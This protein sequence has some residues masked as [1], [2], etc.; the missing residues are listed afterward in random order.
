MGEEEIKNSIL[1]MFSFIQGRF[2]GEVYVTVDEVKARDINFQIIAI[3]MVDII[4]INQSSQYQTAKTRRNHFKKRIL[5]GCWVT[6]RIA[7]AAKNEAQEIVMNK[8]IRKLARTAQ[9][10]IKPQ[11]LSREDTA[12]TTTVQFGFSDYT[13]CTSSSDSWMPLQAPLLLV[14][15]KIDV[16]AAG[17]GADFLSS[18]FLHLTSPK[19]E[20][21]WIL[22]IGQALA[23]CPWVMHQP[24]VRYV[25]SE[26]QEYFGHSTMLLRVS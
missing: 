7:R 1:Q 18:L 4:Y 11:I 2:Q 16:A 26:T 8:G 19:V 23:M 6:H 15:W 17:I 12:T 22:L 13:A 3:H 21:W 24:P 9:T 25:P 20:E 10:T 5:N 14:P